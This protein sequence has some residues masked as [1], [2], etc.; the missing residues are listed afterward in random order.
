MV[1]RGRDSGR[2][3]A[4]SGQQYARVKFLDGDKEDIDSQELKGIL[5][6]PTEAK[7]YLTAEAEGVRPAQ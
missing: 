5:L 3:D 6:T 7:F 4:E 2:G 1:L